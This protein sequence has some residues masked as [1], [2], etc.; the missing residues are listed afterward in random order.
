LD[1]I[2]APTQ[3]AFVLGR[4]I[5][6]NALNASECLHALKH[7]SNVSKN[8]GAYKLDLTK[9]YDHVD[10]GVLEWILRWLGF[11]SHWVRCIMECVTTIRYS[12]C[13][14]N[15]ALEPFCPTGGI[16]QGDPLSLYL[17]LFVADALSR[18]FCKRRW[19]GGL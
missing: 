2:I 15:V 16:R 12:I 13:F 5:I 6:D 9:A 19:V 10:W 7:G 11:Q 17:F 14:N 4:L 8:F 3:S 1:D 18:L